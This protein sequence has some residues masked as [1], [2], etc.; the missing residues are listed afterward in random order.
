MRLE[1]GQKRP[2][3]HPSAGIWHL[4]CPQQVVVSPCTT[5]HRL[6]A[7][8]LLPG[9]HYFATVL[10]INDEG[11]WRSF[12]EDFTTLRRRVTVTFTELEVVND[13]DDNATGEAQF[14]L[15]IL[16]GARYSRDMEIERE[17]PYENG[18]LSY[19]T[20]GCPINLEPL[21]LTHVMGPE[22]VRPKD[23]YVAIRVLGTEDGGNGGNWFFSWFGSEESASSYAW[24]LILPTGTGKEQVINA[25]EFAHAFPKEPPNHNFEFKV[26][27]RYSVEY[28]A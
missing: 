14:K 27:V 21:N 7:L 18:N 12:Q 2:V 15:Q 5:D 4:P 6:E 16:R 26:T 19:T 13:R 10:L 1:V 22:K 28:M 25:R 8:D 24:P 11:R 9:H 23:R 20:N 17:F 3:R